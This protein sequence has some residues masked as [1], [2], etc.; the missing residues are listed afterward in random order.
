MR[1]RATGNSVPFTA[2]L[3]K[4]KHE[5]KGRV[6]QDRRAPTLI[7]TRNLA[8]AAAVASGVAL[9]PA[10]ADAR[11]YYN[12]CTPPR[13]NQFGTAYWHAANT[14]TYD[15]TYAAQGC[16]GGTGNGT[17]C[18]GYKHSTSLQIC[19]KRSQRVT[20][21]S[22]KFGVTVIPFTRLCGSGC[23]PTIYR[24]HELEGSSQ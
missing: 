21:S 9:L 2:T 12:H 16:N 10:S 18:A 20:S 22:L 8:A 6:T 1:F 11:V 19:P 3:G 5:G 15:W 24:S 7:S 4:A 17:P 23:G 14:Y 13:S